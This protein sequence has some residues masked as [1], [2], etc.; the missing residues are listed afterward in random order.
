[1]HLTLF[2][3]DRVQGGRIY[4]DAT[5]QV[6]LG[7]R[8]GRQLIILNWSEKNEFFLVNAICESHGVIGHVI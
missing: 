2:I 3:S 6:T 7:C 5:K 1:M 8:S 4:H